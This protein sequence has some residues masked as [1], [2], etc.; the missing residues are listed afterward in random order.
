MNVFESNPNPNP[1]SVFYT[2]RKDGSEVVRILVVWVTQKQV[3]KL[4][5]YLVTFAL[6]ITI[7][8]HV[9]CCPWCFHIWIW[10]L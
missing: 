5:S 6:F 7:Y 1:R 2:F 10:R 9:A 4:F 3:S 8:C